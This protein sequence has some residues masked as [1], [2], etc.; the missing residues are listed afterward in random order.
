MGENS[1]GENTAPVGAWASYDDRAGGL[2][3]SPFFTSWD[4]WDQILLRNST[5]RVKK[6]FKAYYNSRDFDDGAINPEDR[7]GFI[8]I[9]RLRE[10]LKPAPGRRLLNWRLRRRLRTNP[11]NADGD[12][13]ENE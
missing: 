6:L 12:L 1:I 9:Q 8:A 4:E 10:S 7:P 2:F 11:F 13:C 5:R 3:A